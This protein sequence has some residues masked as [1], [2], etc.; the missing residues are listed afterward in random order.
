MTKTSVVI[1]AAGFGTRM[2]SKLAKVLHR[3]GGITLIE[4]VIRAARAVAQPSDIVAI[5]GHQADTVA[6]LVAPLGLRTALQADPQGTGHA[7]AQARPLLENAGG[8]LVILSG[9]VPLL[10]PASVQRLVAEHEASGKDATVMTCT[11]DDP[12]AYGRIVRDADGD[13]AAIVEF[14]ACSEEEKKIREINSGIYCFNADLV[15]KYIGDITTDNPAGEYYLTDL[16]GIFR[17]NAHKVG[18]MQIADFNELLGINNKVELAAM[19]QM[20]RTRKVRELMLDGV[21]IERPESVTVD[22]DVRVGRDALLEPNVRLTGAT[23]IGEDT[24]IGTGSVIEDSTIGANVQILPYTV[25]SE[26]EVGDG[27][28]IGPFARLRNHNQ[29]GANCRIGNFVELKKT[30][31]GAGAKANHL[32]YLGD[33]EIGSKSNIG[34]GTITCNYDGVNK[35]KTRIG[36][37]AFVGSNSTLVAPIEIGSGAYVAAGSVITEAVPETALALG[38]ARQI[39]KTGWKPKNTAK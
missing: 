26:S 36:E 2:K 15:W 27:A 30:S 1:M 21:T 6:K 20:F 4:H 39:I 35:H 3:A 31:M 16:I 33:A 7:V 22:V 9:D 14:K 12:A 11:I 29:V 10:S 37:K 13:V 8:L 23:V 32:A 38:R 19:D 25:I 34:A 17:R 18:A 24:R 5:I 28:Q